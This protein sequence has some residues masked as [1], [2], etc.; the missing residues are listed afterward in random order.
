MLRRPGWEASHGKAS[1]EGDVM[2]GREASAEEIYKEGY[3]ECRKDVVVWLTI[4]SAPVAAKAIADGCADG[5]A[6]GG[7]KAP[8]CK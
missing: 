1:E 6:L 3:E 4:F 8:K 5:F 2:D 7:K